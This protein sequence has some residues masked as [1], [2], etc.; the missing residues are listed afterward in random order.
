MSAITWEYKHFNELDTHELYSILKIR[1]E[2]FIVEQNCAYLDEDDKDLDAWHLF[3]LKNELIIAYAR[4][5][6][7]GVAFA[8]ASIGRVL[9]IKNYRK[10]GA[11]RTLM[12]HAIEKTLAQYQ[13]NKI[14]IG[15]QVY[16]QDFYTSLGFT[17][18][19]AQYMEDGI[20][21]MEMLLTK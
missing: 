8:E 20:P 14:K 19:S 18:T 5:L 12:L 9:T 3:A 2:V 16:L 4:I 10:N 15:A 17:A 1:N 7:P 6:A 21:H 13:V 11:G